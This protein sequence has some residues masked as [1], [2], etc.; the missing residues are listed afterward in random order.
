MR[1]QRAVR[2]LRVSVAVCGV[3]AS[4]LLGDGTQAQPGPNP[5][6]VVGGMLGII[7]GVMGQAQ[8]QQLL[9]QQQQQQQQQLQQQQLQ[10]QQIEADRQKAAEEAQQRAR[11][12][13]QA[14]AEAAARQKRIAAQA[15]ADAKAKAD[16]L[17]KKNLEAANKLRA[18]PAFLTI[19]GSDKRDVTVLVVG[20]DTPNVVRNL[21]GDPT[22]QN[23]A[24]ACLPFGGIAAD[25]NTLESLFLVNIKG[26]IEQKGGLTNSSLVMT[27]CDLAKP[28]DYDMIIFSRAQVANGTVETL[29]P[30]VDLIRK[31]EFV[32]FATYTIAG[33]QAEEAAKQKAE[34]AKVARQ[35]AERQ[36]AI[37][38]FQ[39][40]DPGIISG[41][42][43]V[44]PAPVACILSSP[45]ADGL[46]YLLK[47]ADSPFA[48]VV[49]PSTVIRDFPSA[50][51]IFIALKRQDCVAAIAPAGAL[52]DVMAG[53]AR[54]GVG[55][56]VDNGEISA[57]RLA[58]W[59][60]LSA[61]DLAAAQ[62]QQEEAIAAERRRDAEVAAA[63]EQKRLLDE[64]RR[65]NDEAARQEELDRMRKLVVSK[66]TAVVDGF[67][68]KLRKHM[69]SVAD[70]LHDT[71]ERAKTGRV[72]SRQQETV[73]QAKYAE[74][75]MD[76]EPWSDQFETYVKQGWEFGD[77]K[78]SLE[79]YGQAQWQ[80]RTI[81]AIAV[82]VEFP[83]I[84]RLIGDKHTD[85]YDFIWIND[86]EFRYMRQAT[87]VKCGG[88]QSAFA[89][90]AQAN[91]FVSQ[92][93]L[94]AG[95]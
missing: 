30:L 10:Q 63:A 5:A 90:W 31:R 37:T 82:K 22:F 11:E 56:E 38:S 17:E 65:K 51:A 66:A 70:E 76:F 68:A 45:D 62:Q 27:A 39:T 16:A 13:Q 26:Q 43:I 8:Q 12:R 58:D 88:Y 71:Q 55:A 1:S 33:F 78:A 67:A 89:E 54:D 80:Q 83:M 49:T 84:N 61:Q 46:R 52:R 59:K 35:A 79:D 73:L 72:L 75:R 94:L 6:N 28:A 92:W 74:A 24:T 47:R 9:Q 81:E 91:G 36:A 32:L 7:Q 23:G 25:P 18:D 48:R 41:I 77:I 19:L 14:E 15:A 20:Q 42:H 50:D 44:S 85:C 40:R 57:D 29:S 86:E 95:P 4:L 69:D 2:A 87:V 34:R 64:Q 21:K 53:L 93:N 3:A 60:T